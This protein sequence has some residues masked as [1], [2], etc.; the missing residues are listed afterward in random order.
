MCCTIHSLPHLLLGPDGR[1]A[2][3]SESSH[4]SKPMRY[5]KPHCLMPSP[6]LVLGNCAQLVEYD[7]NQTTPYNAMTARLADVGG[8]GMSTEFIMIHC[9]T[10]LHLA[11]THPFLC[12]KY[13]LYTTIILA[14]QANGCADKA[15]HHNRHV[16][17][18]NANI[19][20]VATSQ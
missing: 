4:I 1:R 10:G 15:Q 6:Y 17:H 2:C 9:A 12:Y 14:E 8:E 20:A 7:Q 11:Y 13:T 16:R 5:N 3:N 19:P 18:P